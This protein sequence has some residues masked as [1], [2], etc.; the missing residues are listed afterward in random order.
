MYKEVI[1]AKINGEKEVYDPS[2]HWLE[3]PWITV[4]QLTNITLEE[5]EWIISH[6]DPVE[7]VSRYFPNI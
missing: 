2:I 7:A 5:W 4:Y 3:K 1:F 6:P